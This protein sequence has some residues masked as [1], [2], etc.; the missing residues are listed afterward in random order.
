MPPRG[1]VPDTDRMVGRDG[2]GRQCHAPGRGKSPWA[3]SSPTASR[4]GSRAPS[5]VFSPDQAAAAGFLGSVVDLEALDGSVRSL[6]V[7]FAWLNHAAHRASKARLRAPLREAVS[8]VLKTDAAE[9][10]GHPS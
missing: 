7:A 1:L 6:A 2:P 5:E 10:G 8:V 3:T 4:T 9:L